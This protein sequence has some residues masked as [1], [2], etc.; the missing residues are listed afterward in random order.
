LRLATLVDALAEEGLS[1]RCLDG[2]AA[3]VEIGGISYHSARVERG[4]LFVAVR[5]FVHDG[6]DYVG[7]AVRRGAAAVVLERE[8]GAGVAARVLV[9]DARRA[10]AV[11]ACEVYGHPSR[12]LEVVGV[13]GTNG[14]TTTAFL[15]RA[16][17]AAAGRETGL[18]GTVQ[19]AVRDRTYPVTRTTP[20][21]VDLQRLLARMADEGVTHVVME[22]SSHALSLHRLDGTRF[23]AAAFT[24]LT[25]DHLDFH[26]DLRGYL[27]AKA[28]LLDLLEGTAVVNADDP[29]LEEL[30]R[31]RPDAVTFGLGADAEVRAES[32][33]LH[34]RG[35]SFELVTPSGRRRVNLSLAGRFNVYNALAAAALS[36]SLGAD[37]DQVVAGLEGVRGVPG[38]FEM[39]D[40]GQPFAVV[41]DYAHTPDGL[42][43]VLRAA[44][45]V[46][47]RRVIAVFG[48]GGD[49][50]RAKRP[51]MG[52]IAVELADLVFI[53]SD[54][55][56]SEEPDAIIAEVE[57]GARDAGRAG[58]YR[59]EPDR[60]RAIAA[61]VGAAE[62]GDVVIVAGKGHETEQVFRD[63]TIHFDD[64]EAAR[65]ALRG[66]RP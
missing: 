23:A 54:N 51:I 12:R 7:E 14:K 47:E 39:V 49:R 10:M 44:R 33:S 8:V 34:L 20:E 65:A 64:R 4:D 41:V 45:E 62:R 61:A 55:P 58:R 46:T 25:Q 40:E 63:R 35:S 60:A 53:T 59:I 50:D 13:T 19:Y 43:N 6:H 21:A 27:E 2:G 22:A 3:S 15:A 37:L 24:N 57:R 66:D 28:K 5:G 9:E 16:A 32:V 52:R 31:R 11:L 56:R 48:C 29:A 42:A 17:L 36:L 1:P 18:I 30:V 26:E 38:R